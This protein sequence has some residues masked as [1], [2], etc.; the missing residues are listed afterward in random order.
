MLDVF[1]YTF[2][3]SGPVAANDRGIAEPEG[4]SEGTTNV[5]V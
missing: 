5:I 2:M 4:A 1:E 3:P